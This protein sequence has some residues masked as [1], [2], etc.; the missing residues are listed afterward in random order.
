MLEYVN[1]TYLN[2]FGYSGFYE[3][4]NRPILD[5]IV[6]SCRDTVRIIS[7]AHSKKDEAPDF[8]ETRGL[9]KDGTEFD[10]E[11]KSSIYV[12]DK[13]RYTLALI[14]DI[15][16]RKLQQSAMLERLK[17]LK[18]MNEVRRLFGQTLSLDMLCGKIADEITM[19]MQFPRKAISVIN[20]DGKRYASGHYLDLTCQNIEDL[21][22]GIHQILSV[23]GNLKDNCRYIILTVVLF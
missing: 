1:P 22:N 11:V 19:A 6:P 18:C 15:T 14:R 8:Y 7:T 16:E 13:K 21:N 20:I 23:S 4:Y 12:L 17:E 5:L 2:L 9:R 10:M 3:L